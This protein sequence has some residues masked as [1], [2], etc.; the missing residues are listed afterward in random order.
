[1]QSTMG[2]GGC[3]MYFLFGTFDFLS[4]VFVWFFLPETK[5]ISLE[6]MDALFSTVDRS[7]R[8]D[9][10]PEIGVEANKFR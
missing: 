9:N 1:M 8:L 4:G 7:K 10:E 3:G 5:G 2:T 6:H